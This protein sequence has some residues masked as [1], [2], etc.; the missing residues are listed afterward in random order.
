M[1]FDEG[2][3]GE[4]VYSIMF[5][6]VYT[7]GTKIEANANKYAWILKKACITNLSKQ[8]FYV[9]YTA[10]YRNQQFRIKPNENH[11]VRNNDFTEIIYSIERNTSLAEEYKIKKPRSFLQ[12][13]MCFY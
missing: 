10:D 12:R 7:D 1:N 9:F 13:E 5:G 3:K 2:I 6:H 4:R 11:I 8:N